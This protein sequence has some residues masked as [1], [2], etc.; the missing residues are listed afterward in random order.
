LRL[1]SFPF[2]RL[3]LIA[4]I[5]AAGRDLFVVPAGIPHQFQVAGWDSSVYLLIKVRR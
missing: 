2:G 5:G 1:A 4:G 3:R